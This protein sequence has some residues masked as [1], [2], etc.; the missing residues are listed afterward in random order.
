MS[1]LTKEMLDQ[2]RQRL[3]DTT[4]MADSAWKE[5]QAFEESMKTMVETQNSLRSKWAD[6]YSECRT[7][8]SII[9]KN[10]KPTT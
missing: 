2:F 7:I 8:Q 3:A 5:Y 4:T 9:D 10:E 1:D 6:L